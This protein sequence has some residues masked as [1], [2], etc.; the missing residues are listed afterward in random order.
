MFA[1]ISLS[2]NAGTGVAVLPA[3]PWGT[4]VRGFWIF[5]GG[6]D[7][8]VRLSGIGSSQEVVTTAALSVGLPVVTSAAAGGP[9]DIPIFAVTGGAWAFV[10]CDH[11]I[12]EDGVSRFAVSVAT[13]GAGTFVVTVDAELPRQVNAVQLGRP[14]APVAKDEPT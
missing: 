9:G 1:S 8:T 10:P 11:V 14:P 13:A 3:L 2:V 7:A 4:R 12:G 5:G 6:A